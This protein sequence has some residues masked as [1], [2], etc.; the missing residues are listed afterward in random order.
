[1]LAYPVCR[2]PLQSSIESE[3][4]HKSEERVSNFFGKLEISVG[5]VV[6]VSKPKLLP[7]NF[8]QCVSDL[9]ISSFSFDFSVGSREGV[10]ALHPCS[11]IDLPQPPLV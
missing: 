2:Q 7:Q 9:N 4:D 10:F 6:N 1:L 8:F 3:K 11:S 5:R